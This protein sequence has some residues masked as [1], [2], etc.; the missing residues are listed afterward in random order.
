MVSIAGVIEGVPEKAK[1]EKVVDETGYLKVVAWVRKDIFM[2]VRSM[3]YV[4]KG[5]RI[6]YFTASDIEKIQNVWTAKKANYE[7]HTEE[8]NGAYDDPDV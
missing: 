7:N 6:K 5:R 8:K 3:L 4:K 1:L 2:T